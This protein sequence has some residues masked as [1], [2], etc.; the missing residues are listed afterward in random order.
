MD[1][2]TAAGDSYLR[3]KSVEWKFADLPSAR[4]LPHPD[5]S[6]RLV[7]TGGAKTGLRSILNWRQIAAHETIE[8]AFAGFSPGGGGQFELDSHRHSHPPKYISILTQLSFGSIIKGALRT[9]C[10]GC[11]LG[12]V[13]HEAV[14]HFMEC[15][16][17]TTK[18]YP[19]GRNEEELCHAPE[20]LQ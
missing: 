12:L 15:K 4:S 14:M 1:F 16:S 20:L 7:P 8:C 6:R 5:R 19:N 9:R 10:E 3:S 17:L 18:R 11:H 2:R 13:R